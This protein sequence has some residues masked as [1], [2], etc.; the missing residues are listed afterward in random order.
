M[1]VAETIGIR[2]SKPGMRSRCLAFADRVIVIKIGE[3]LMPKSKVDEPDRSRVAAD[4]DV[5]YLARKHG[6]NR[7]KKIVERVGT[8]RQKLDQAARKLKRAEKR[9]VTPDSVG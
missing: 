5:Q 7:Q 9:A 2:I 4:D 1:A 3:V 6:L 8:D